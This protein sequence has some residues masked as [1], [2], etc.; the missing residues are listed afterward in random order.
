MVS[1]AAFVALT[2]VLDALP[3]QT[4]EP[5]FLRWLRALEAHPLRVPLGL[6]L[7]WLGGSRLVRAAFRRPEP[8][9]R[10]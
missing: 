5:L 10:A 6:T 2:W 9:T 8:T 3:A 7:A 1:S 4:G